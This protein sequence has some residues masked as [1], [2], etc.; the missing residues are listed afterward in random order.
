MMRGA[1]GGAA[2]A[3]GSSW[4]G[5]APLRRAPS[6]DAPSPS[7]LPCR[8]SD[9]EP[10]EEAAQKLRLI[11]IYNRRLDERQRRKDFVLARGLLNVKRQAAL[12][13][14]RGPTERELVGRLR[15]LAPAL[16][17]PQWEALAE[18]LAAEARLRGR[19]AELQ[20]Y[21]SLGMRTFEQVDRFETV[22]A[23]KRRGECNQ[24]A[25]GCCMGGALGWLG[26]GGHRAA[27]C[28]SGG[29]SWRRVG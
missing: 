24:L 22:E 1:G 11:Q 26:F 16:S 18:G 10:P 28:G 27:G 2:A 20:R 7:H 12:D 17:Q 6:A 3:P 19:I 23:K 14:R 9:D 5:F 4:L 15:V 8:R 25:L 29:R 13:R 21:R